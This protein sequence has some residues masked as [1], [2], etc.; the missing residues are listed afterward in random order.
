MPPMPTMPDREAVPPMT[1]MGPDEPTASDMNA[2]SEEL[3]LLFNDDVVL[4]FFILNKNTEII[5]STTHEERQT[6]NI[7]N[8][9]RKKGLFYKIQE[10]IND[11][12]TPFQ[13]Q[14]I[15]DTTM[16]RGINAIIIHPI[17]GVNDLDLMGLAV[18]TVQD[19]FIQNNFNELMAFDAKGEVYFVNSSGDF[20]T[21]S[22]NKHIL[23]D[24][25]GFNPENYTKNIPINNPGKK[26]RYKQIS[27]NEYLN[28]PSTEI[29]QKIMQK[30]EKPIVINRP[31]ANYYGEKVIG[32][33][34]WNDNIQ[35]ALVYEITIFDLLSD[36]LWLQG[37]TIFLIIIIVIFFLVITINIDKHRINALD[38]NPLT[39]LPGNRSINNHL[40]KILKNKTDISVVYCDLDNFKAYNDA[41]GFGEGDR[42]LTFTGELINNI[43]KRHNFADSFVGHIGGDDFMYI[44]PHPACEKI[45]QEIGRDFEKGIKD[46]YNEEDLKNNGIKAKGRTE[47]VQFFPLMSL[48][49]GGVHT[50]NHQFTHH[51][52]IISIC[53]EVK[54]LAKKQPGSILVVDRRY[55]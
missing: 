41:Y 44:V 21:P 12:D 33:A 35:M 1:K 19:Y 11:S 47:E 25:V 28:A 6:S 10:D 42:V 3:S 20:L 37:L 52:Q 36:W 8:E 18:F 9:F 55:K 48:S 32:F 30:P 50:C 13:T 29:I 39:H 23:F 27:L 2:M 14:I 4:D 26:L 46:F 40:T 31:Y 15:L 22:K 7:F 16:S 51:L 17:F 24:S 49:M 34:I 54:T 53:S 43:V 45:A 5:L 38:F